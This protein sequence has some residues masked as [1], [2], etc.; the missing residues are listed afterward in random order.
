MLSSSSAMRLLHTPLN[1][2]DHA[3]VAQDYVAGVAVRWVVVDSGPLSINPLALAVLFLV[4]AV[5]HVHT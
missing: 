1:V 4:V 5:S 3:D 2:A